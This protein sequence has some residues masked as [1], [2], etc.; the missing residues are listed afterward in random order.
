M[1]LFRLKSS[2]LIQVSGDAKL[3][4][5]T[6]GS[7]ILSPRM[8]SPLSRDS[9]KFDLVA[10]KIFA[11]PLLFHAAAFQELSSNATESFREREF[12]SHASEQEKLEQR[13]I[14]SITASNSHKYAAPASFIAGKEFCIL[15]TCALFTTEI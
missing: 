8:G 9:T 14:S 3:Y 5:S 2:S 13:A 12:R 4:V 7:S 6:A 1:D 15:C 11:D 10:D